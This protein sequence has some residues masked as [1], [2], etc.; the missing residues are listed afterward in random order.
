[1]KKD[2]SF[3]DVT[4][5]RVGLSSAATKKIM[6]LRQVLCP[7][8]HSQPIHLIPHDDLVCFSGNVSALILHLGRDP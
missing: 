3:C 1:M 7:L 2:F 5:Q 4:C 6:C 8:I